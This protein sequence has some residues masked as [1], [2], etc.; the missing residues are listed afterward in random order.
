[1]RHKR[2]FVSGGAGV[3]GQALVELLLRE[4]A[5]VFVGDLKP[6][7]SAW[8]GQVIYRQGDL[9]EITA[10]ELKAFNPELFFHLA[11]TF[12]RSEETAPFFNE[13]YHHNVQLSHH[14]MAI[15][16]ECRDLTRVVFASSYLIYDPE[17]YQFKTPCQAPVPLKEEDAIL[18]RN[19]CGAAKLFHELELR[20]LHTV[21]AGSPTFIA[22]R[23]FRVYGRHSRD[24]I[25]RWIRAA[26][27]SETLT[28]YRP[29][30]KFDYIFADDVAEGLMRLAKTN[31]C[32]VV[33]L[34][35][36]HARSVQEVLDVLKRHF[37]KLKVENQACE[38]PFEGSEASMQKCQVLTGWQPSQ[39]L[40]STIPKLIEFEKQH[41]YLEEKLP[42]LRVLIT[43]LSKKMG[44]IK[45]VRN[46]AQ[47][48]GSS[49]PIYGSDNDPQCVGKYGV[50]A[51]WH[52]PLL[53]D[54]TE[55]DFLH[56][57]QEHSIQVIIPTRDAEL[58]FFAQHRHFFETHQI[59]VMVSQQETIENCL[60]K[61]RF[62]QKLMEK[63]FLAIPTELTLADMT[64]P[65]FVVK[66]RYGSGSKEIG[67]KLS[68]EAALEHS[69]QLRH[70]IFQP[71]IKGIEW[72][73]DLY[74]SRQGQ[75]KGVVARQRNV[76]VNGESQV[77][78]T[79]RY[80]Q[81]EKL[82]SDIADYL[83]VEGHA[84]F[85]AIQAE[86]DRLWVIECNPRF[87]GASTASLAVGLDS[88]YWFFLE[89]LGRDLKGYVFNR[90]AQ[91]IRQVRYPMD[92]I[93]P[94]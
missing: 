43:S 35:S 32:G 71:F 18:P 57:C 46:A 21:S 73:I 44:L 69:K 23:I 54:L 68:K 86:D 82:C 20:F 15:L 89:S 47:K 4:G 13:N 29:E 90:L 63:G 1:M 52:S 24:I 31:Y 14:L 87:G 93:I 10:D 19:I 3:I 2:V 74:R 30:G 84:V 28:V 72:S 67:L 55:Q 7:P 45:A 91:E 92:R 81:L 34:G 40:E 83:N 70:P 38:I 25:S 48:I 61:K 22:A 8:K 77:T 41:P 56:Y 27:K 37:P 5:Q 59:Q 65:Y 17:L 42:S 64:V 58:P 12:E 80:P 49:E 11:A 60:D 75:V 51:F 50:D 53:K 88:F 9:N 76:V 36:G 66:E 39:H 33:N 85:Q 26:L 6:C 79:A 94:L 16:K 62:A 78:T